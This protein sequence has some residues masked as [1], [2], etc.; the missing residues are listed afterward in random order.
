MR[1]DDPFVY[2]DKWGD[3]PRPVS[4]MER[5]VDVSE[6]FVKQKVNLAIVRIKKEQDFL[7]NQ[8][9]KFVETLND[10]ELLEDEFYTR[11]KYG[12][13]DERKITMMKNGF[14]A[15]LAFLLLEKYAGYLTIDIQANTVDLKES[16][17]TAM[18]DN[19]EN[20]LHT[21]EAGFYTSE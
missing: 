19:G 11:I 8:I 12:T 4:Y 20:R 13:T 2:V 6:K 15:G 3:T 21:F 10:M 1:I 5:W 7:D 14:S 9:M 16:A 18:E 17:E